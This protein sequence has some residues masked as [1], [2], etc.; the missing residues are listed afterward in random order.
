MP[1]LMAYAVFITAALLLMGVVCGVLRLL[2][3]LL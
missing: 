2:E 3:V 1:L